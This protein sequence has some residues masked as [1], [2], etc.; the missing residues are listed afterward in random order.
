MRCSN[1]HLGLHIPY[2]S[3]RLID[4]RGLINNLPPIVL[5]EAALLSDRLCLPDAAVAAE[6]SR[7][8]ENFPP[9]EQFA[10]GPNR[11]VYV[12]LALAGTLRPA[13]LAS[14]S[15]ALAFLTAL[16]PSERLGA[17]YRLAQAVAEESQRLQGVRVD[18]TILWGA[19][20]EVA[21]EDER[22]RLNIEA[23]EWQAQALH[24]T[25]KYAPATNVW[26]RW[27]K[28]GGLI[29]QLMAPV[30]RGGSDGDTT[31][32]EIVVKLEDRKKFEEQVI[33]TDRV[34]IGRRRGQDIHAG[35]LNRLHAHAQE[36]VEF[37]HCHLSLNSSRPSQ[38]DFLTRAL[39]DLREQVGRLAP[40]ALQELRDCAGGEKSLLAGAANTSVHAIERF[41]EFLNPEEMILDREPNPRE[42]V[43]SGLYG[44]SSL[45]IRDDGSPED[46][47]LVALDT[48]L[49]TGRPEELQSAFDSG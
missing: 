33:K 49:Y 44:F 40:P 27:L 30:T 35:A 14:Q 19:G 25:I 45:N 22:E 20:S 24:K 4:R 8:L 31:I 38:S 46:D 11:D 41:R 13:L 1:L 15:G 2:R 47:D 29:S 6:L 17:V 18:S 28:S 39:A 10:T 26:Q 9:P 16:K 32:K 43:A 3:P 34:E 23:A 48:L 42:L 12:M 21:W 36:A 37:A 7:V 5:L